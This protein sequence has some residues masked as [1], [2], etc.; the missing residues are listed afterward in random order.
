MLSPVFEATAHFF[1][2]APPGARIRRFLMYPPPPT[3]GTY[4]AGRGLRSLPRDCTIS[5]PALTRPP[6]AVHVKVIGS[7]TVP[8]PDL[9][10]DELELLRR[11]EK[12]GCLSL[13]CELPGERC[14]FVFGLQLRYSFVPV[15]HLVYCHDFGDFVR[16][17]GAIGRFLLR[18]GY[19]FVIF[20]SNGP[21]Q[22]IVGKHFGDRP[23]FRRGGDQVR[24]GDVA[25]SEQVL[26]GY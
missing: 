12:Y 14:P 23:R 13:I 25:Y 21:V 9:Q 2:C 7:N 20:D 16:F 4:C 11:H 26:F 6:E 22:R 1:R 10:N 15:A 18:R 8:G 17:A 3:P 5:I 19:A 24:L